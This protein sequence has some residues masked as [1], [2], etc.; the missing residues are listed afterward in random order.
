MAK[1]KTKDDLS[2]VKQSAS[3][4]SVSQN[5][6]KGKPVSIAK[7]YK[8]L[9]TKATTPTNKQTTSTSGRGNTSPY[10]SNTQAYRNTAQNYQQR[11]TE[12]YG[13]NRRATN[14]AVNNVKA[15]NE[16]Q[17]IAVDNAQKRKDK[18]NQ[19]PETQSQ[20]LNRLNEK[21]GMGS[22]QHQQQ[23][24]RTNDIIG[25]GARTARGSAKEA[26]G[27]LA[28]A[29]SDDSNR[30][31]E[32]K[33]LLEDMYVN[34]RIDKSTYEKNLASLERSNI[35]KLY[36]GWENS[37]DHKDYQELY[38]WGDELNKKGTAEVQKELEGKEGLEK[39]YLQAVNSGTGMAIDAAVNFVVPGAGLDAMG[40][41]ILGNNTDANEQFAFKP[42][43]SGRTRLE[44]RRNAMTQAWTE[45]FTEKIFGGVGIGRAA[46]ANKMG[47]AGAVELADKVADFAGSKFKGK[48]GN[49]A[50]AAARLLMGSAEENAEEAIS[51]V[52]GPLLENFSYGNAQQTRNENAVRDSLNEYV[53]SLSEGD[54]KAMVSYLNSDDYVDQ[55]AKMYMEDDIPE[56]D[57]YKS[58]RLM[59]DYLAAEMS[60]DKEGAKELQDK[61]VKAST[62]GENSVKSTWDTKELLDTVAS[63]TLL[64]TVTGMP[65]TATHAATMSK[66]G[67][68][69]RADK[70]LEEVKVLAK[71]VQNVEDGNMAERAKAMSEHLQSGG[72]VSDIQIGEMFQSLMDQSEKDFVRQQSAYDSAVERIQEE[73]G[74]MP[75]RYSADGES[76]ALSETASKRVDYY[77]KQAQNIIDASK[78]S[79]DISKEE[80]QFIADTIGGFET[81]YVTPSSANMLCFANSEARMIFKEATGIDLDAETIEYDKNGNVDIAKTN[82]NTKDFLFTRAAQNLVNTANIERANQINTVKGEIDPQ[83]TKNFGGSGQSAFMEASSVMDI[84]SPKNYL[85]ASD[86]FSQY[87][88]AARHSGV[89]SMEEFQQKYG[90][91]AYDMLPYAVRQQAFEAGLED[92]QRER[93]PIGAR[94]ENGKLIGNTAHKGKGTVDV[95]TENPILASTHELFQS[96][97]R[98][99]GLTIHIVDTIYD[100]NGNV[101][102]ANGAYSNG[103]IWLNINAPTGETMEYTLMHEITHAIKNIAPNE[104]YKLQDLIVEKWYDN[105]KD[106]FM[107]A[108]DKKYAAYNMV[109][110]TDRETAI[111]ELIAS[112]M[113][114]LL[115]SESFIEEVCQDETLARTILNAIR[116][117][118]QKLRELF[119]MNGGFAPEYN[120]AL[121]QQLDIMKEAERLFLDGLAAMA[122]VK[123]EEVQMEA[124]ELDAKYME[125]V[126]AGDTKTAKRMV[127]DAAKKAGYTIKGYHGTKSDFNIFKRGDVGFHF[128]S[129]KAI[130]TTRVGKGKDS[131]IIEAAIK[132]N[133]PI[134]LDYDIGDWSADFSS[135][136]RMLVD[137][138]GIVTS[139][140]YASILKQKNKNAALR[141]L[142][143]EKGY[144]GFQYDNYYESDGKKSYIVFDSN[145]IKSADPVTYDDDG[146]VIPLS[147][148]FNDKNEDI[149]YSVF[150]PFDVQVDKTF[151]HE[152]QSSDA[153]Y[154]GETPSILMDAG[155]GNLPMLITQ[156]HVRDAVKEKTKDGHGIPK[157]TIKKLPAAIKEPA[158]IADSLSTASEE[159]VVVVTDLEDPD[160]NP[161]I[162]SIMPD[163]AGHYVLDLDSNFVTSVYGRSQF[164]NFVKNCLDENKILYISNKKSQVLSDRIQLQ[165]LQR[166]QGL[167]FDTIIQKSKHVVNGQSQKNNGGSLQGIYLSEIKT[168]EETGDWER[169]R[170]FVKRVAR[171]RGFK[172]VELEVGRKKP[173]DYARFVSADGQVKSGD[174]VTYDSNGE[175]IPLEKR[176]DTNDTNPLYSL[177]DTDIQ[178]LNNIGV[179]VTDGGSVTR[180]SLNSWENTDIDKLKNV[181]SDAGYEAAKVEKWISDVNSV[182]AVIANDRGRLDYIADENQPALKPNAE[183][184]YT[185][186]LSTLC[187]KRRLYQGTYNAIMHRLVNKALTPEDTIRIRAMMDEMGYEVPCGICYEESRK[188]NEG[189]FAERWLNGHGKKWKGYKN[190]EHEDPYVPTL[191][192]VTTTDGRDKLR[193][194]HPEA[195][196]SYLKYQ[197]TRGSANPKVSFTHTDYR[198]DIMNMTANDVEKVKHIGG[199]RI[200]SFSD[201]EIPHVIDMMQAVMDMSAKNLTAQ[202]YTKVPAFADIFGGTGIKINLSLIGKVNPE[203]GELEFNPKEGI[204]PDEAFRLREK[205]SENVGT[206]IVGANDASI[207]AAWADPRIDMVI[208]FHR[209]GWKLKEFEKLGL[210]DYK[211][212]QK[213]Q[214]ER[215]LNGSKNGQALSRASKATGQKM[216][217]I[218]SEDYWDYSK[219][220]KENAE[221]YLK[222]CAEKKYRP[223]FYNF[224]VNNG[225]GSYSL[226]P[227]GSTDGYWKSLVDFKMYNNEGIGAAQ[228][229][230]RPEFDME[231]AQKVMDSYEGGADTLPVAQ[232]VVD[233]FVEGKEQKLFSLPETD[234]EG[235]QLTE[236]Q[237]EYFKDSKAVDEN[238]RLVPVYHSTDNGGFTIFNPHFSDDRRSL[239]FASNPRVSASYSRNKDLQQYNKESFEGDV[240]RSGQYATYLNLKNP[241]VIDGRGSRWSEVPYATGESWQKVYSKIED[242][243]ADLREE[244]PDDYE[245]YA[246]DLPMYVFEDFN[247]QDVSADDV[248]GQ[249]TYHYAFRGKKYNVETSEWETFDT[250]DTVSIDGDFEDLS[251]VD[252][253]D[254][255][256]HI[257]NAFTETLGTDW[258]IYNDVAD[259]LMNSNGEIILRSGV[260]FTGNWDFESDYNAM[261]PKTTASTRMIAKDAQQNGYDGVIIKNIYDIGNGN[262]VNETS[263]IYIAFESNQVKLTDNEAP[264][265]N[266][267][268][269]FSI[270]ESDSEGNTLTPGQRAYFENTKA[271]DKNGNLMIMYHGTNT[272]GF[273][274]FDKAHGHP[275]G[276]S[277]AGFYFSNQQADSDSNYGSP[278]G[279]DIT[280]K[281]ERLAETIDAR[282]EWRGE[283]VDSYERAKELAEDELLG[284]IGVYQVYLNTVNPY[285]RAGKNSTNLYDII[286]E[287][288]DES[289]VDRDDYDSDEDYEDDLYNYRA[290]SMYETIDTAVSAAFESVESIWGDVDTFGSWIDIVNGIMEKAEGESLTWDDVRDVFD[291]AGAMVYDED[292]GDMMVAHEM[293]RAF[294]EALGFDSVID[295]EVS[296]KFSNMGNMDADTVHIIVFKPEQIKNVDNQNPSTSEDIR[297]SLVQDPSITEPMTMEAPDEE[298]MLEYLSS[299]TDDDADMPTDDIAIIESRQRRVDLRKELADYAASKNRFDPTKLT[300][301]R[302]LD[303]KSVKADVQN[304][305]M[306]AMQNSETKK[307]YKTAQVTLATNAA[308]KIF[309][310]IK[311][312]DYDGAS[313]T[314]FDTAA[315]IIENLDLVD[316]ATFAEY[317]AFRDYFKSQKIYVNEKT[318]AD[319]GS[320]W[321]DFRKA[322]LGWLKM[323][324]DSSK[325]MGIDQLWDEIRDRF[326]QLSLSDGMAAQSDLLQE[327]EDRYEGLSNY[328]TAYESEEAYDLIKGMAEDLF[329]I[330]YD[331][332]AWKS[333]ADKKKA[334][335]DERTKLLKQRHKEALREAKQKERTKA[336]KKIKQLKDA[337]KDK[338][339]DAT[340]R[341]LKRGAKTNVAYKLGKADQR[342]KTKE[343]NAKKKQRQER[344]KDL[345]KIKANY[346]W[347]SSRLA[348][349]TDSKHIPE[350]FRKSLAEALSM[351]DLQTERSVKLEEKKGEAKSTAK[352]RDL[353]EQLEQIAKEDGSGD[354]IYD[355]YVFNLMKSLEKKLEDKPLRELGDQQIKEVSILLSYI[356]KNIQNYNKTVADNYAYEVSVLAKQSKSRFDDFI[357]KRGNK[358]QWTGMV[359]YAS[360]IINI[361]MVTPIDMFEDIGGGLETCYK[362]LRKGFDKHERN[363]KYIR[364]KVF[365]PLLDDYKNKKLGNLPLPGSELESWRDDSQMKE[366]TL[367]SGKTIR[368]NAAQIMSLHCLA[369][370]EQ[371]LGHILGGGIVLSDVDSKRKLGKEIQA[372]TIGVAEEAADRTPVIL[373]ENDLKAIDALLTDE[374][375]HIADAMQSVL[376]TTVAE[377]GNETSMKLNGYRKFTEENYFPIR[378]DSDFLITHFDG[379]D[380]AERIKNF[381]FTKE[382]VKHAN[383]AIMVEDFFTVVADHINKMSLYNALAAPIQDFQRVYNYKESGE[384]IEELVEKEDGTKEVKKTVKNGWSTEQMLANAMG[385]KVDNYVQQ[386]IRDLNG[387]TTIRHDETKK[388]LNKLMAN[389]KRAAIGG[390]LRVMLQQPTA[391]VRAADVIH[392]KYLHGNPKNLKATLKE[393]FDHCPIAEWKAMGNYQID[394]TR[395]LESIMMGTDWGVIDAV[396]MGAYGFLDN[397]TWAAIWTACKNEVSDKHPNLEYGSDEY[398]SA[399]N[400]RASYV[401]DKTQVVDSVFHRSHGMRSDSDFMRLVSSFKAEPTRT[402]NMLR[403]DFL[404]AKAMW[405][406]GDKSEA[407]KLAA[408][409]MGVFVANAAFV[410]AAAAIADVI[411]GKGDD[412]EDK[413]TMWYNNFI[414]NLKDNLNVVSSMYVIGDIE[415]L[416][417]KA[418]TGQYNSGTQFMPLEGFSQLATNLNQW[419]KYFMGDSKKTIPELLE[420]TIKSVSYVTGIPAGNVLRD[421][422]GLWNTVGLPS[423]FAAFAADELPNK[424]VTELTEDGVEVDVPTM[425]RN[426][427]SD[428][429]LIKD[430]TTLDNML[431]KIGLNLSAEEKKQKAYSQEQKAIQKKM[432]DWKQKK[433]K[434]GISVTQEEYDKHLWSLCAKG[435]KEQM[436]HGNLKNVQAMARLYEDMGGSR[437]D[438]NDKIATAA[439]SAYKKT[440]GDPELYNNQSALRDYMLNDLGVTQEELSDL[441]Y[442]SE[443]AKKLKAGMRIRDEKMMMGA[444]VDLIHAGLTEEDYNRLWKNRNRGDVS[445][446]LP[447]GFA[448][449]YTWPVNGTITSY[450]G[451]RNAPTAGASTNHQA[452]DIAAAMGT[453]VGSANGGVVK[454]AGVYGGYGNQVVISHPDGSETYYSHLSAINVHEGDTVVQGQDIGAVGST[455]VSTGPHL[456]FK[457]RVSGKWV[458]PLDYLPK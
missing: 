183:Y 180:Y 458:D 87:Y 300:H 6:S 234:S 150:D 275:E 243:H 297:F 293:T 370:R 137:E 309:E 322:N 109:Q 22:E 422:K 199:L 171:E 283:E 143:K 135:M 291:D 345:Y 188:K 456:D 165:L 366:V 280:G 204:D 230:V 245:D 301:E 337:Q 273:T 99:T 66:A 157:D 263:D 220:G 53:S 70:G 83:I 17:Q 393:M 222:L 41:R 144:D 292:S 447:E 376:N 105:D 8:S 452:I 352:M 231:A 271:V 442:K 401:F 451:A 342:E 430:G 274:I 38:K 195:Y 176:F 151:S 212:F 397:V 312:E 81:G 343:A 166:L 167:S 400:E 336:N 421:I 142:L 418:F 354:F 375:R 47:R 405:E 162:A 262:R 152:L 372:R 211:D 96:L 332:E 181:L 19:A 287:Q 88:N 362:N 117:V 237:R 218:Y 236:Q 445:K 43:D 24:K 423:L 140:E 13:Q 186:D 295:S 417:E 175:V 406:E 242:A 294:I 350:G 134:V 258:E 254:I 5:N 25:E 118:L 248:P 349:P 268:I 326:P 85:A 308:Q 306:D 51:W 168:A 455:G 286:A 416:F 233:K 129:V 26:I 361:D 124:A 299:F 217:E 194:E 94:I 316:D 367:A 244:E 52:V 241:L 45:M 340:D 221:A 396:T 377:W 29:W 189:V 15:Y 449:H 28:K 125:A 116:D 84:S 265:E 203:T 44:A 420:G 226:Q 398:W 4:Y 115:R 440:I 360:G 187:A 20:T 56:K 174:L 14:Q 114:E 67:A 267:D 130:A 259:S 49:M 315:E 391:I 42:G 443:T 238:G 10:G 353:R 412:D 359:G 346:E 348:H 196:E 382:L 197:K 154:I 358:K 146:N 328:K 303:V 32:Q 200:Q 59:R 257:G 408:R 454:F 36:K 159:G 404:K 261:M 392:P 331:G 284:D 179:D 249:I 185:L 290:E 120:Q 317:K 305:V 132:L 225:D 319:F 156:K 139:D 16:K 110:E 169:L 239:F 260:V 288:F 433:A 122:E 1:K 310:Q 383:N 403:T 149:R 388:L 413:L 437:D 304:L 78:E 153:V 324:N 128:G 341:A 314:A 111:E 252:M 240:N 282:G 419:R 438:A 414:D 307:K 357:R 69:F 91:P 108:L 347:L 450:F 46:Y 100:K 311:D 62:G 381:G 399:V 97:A 270:P 436:E 113:P 302:V 279:A 365:N 2:R 407:K 251:D 40:S 457:V 93:L 27:G 126:K 246:Y 75:I 7:T 380:S 55:L 208:P 61:I 298:S 444:L 228:T 54:A 50:N 207:L 86:A 289:T 425:N 411:R 12:E 409:T 253:S 206:I 435:Y 266:E 74:S 415:S 269:R 123:A 386:F 235:N 30:Y 9:Q 334:Q 127:L 434:E 232:D 158:M 68:E 355:G 214:S 446:Y 34:G 173:K 164:E 201:F 320:G 60:G 145:Q 172:A 119:A 79:L 255:Y 182:A 155:L 48:M 33:M 374:Q 102:N 57:A 216:E 330:A 133:N 170:K 395:D 39:W 63:T 98:I 379:R 138:K 80:K 209:S 250:E 64:T 389:Y 148:R 161:I 141:N 184:Y 198:G 429:K 35:G 427:G 390:N 327:L 112:H 58:A 323:T 247:V 439:K 147:E 410:S 178:E 104:Y 428:P 321:N 229:E 190:M 11:S 432:D 277:G 285:Y 89:E 387:T 256:D 356:R 37:K 281:I 453:P 371:A 424:D 223:V 163:G 136:Q 31:D 219:T 264:T 18:M 72:D 205:Y 121:L 448:D 394:M 215:Y 351:F 276:N 23:M 335:Y 373:T 76:V 378:S 325:G 192:E 73:G 313:K 402:W 227:D 103:E 71:N 191:D 296:E 160:G 384:I 426:Y 65:G 131:R 224:L 101:V 364:E 385:S 90:S 210:G 193:E 344:A 272:F 369:K 95:Q 106:A 338:I 441:C 363:I 213:Y 77:T 202:A 177:P 318:K 21:Y 329:D 107:A 339:K 278:D 3:Q 368:L 333:F 431:N 92:R 82:Q